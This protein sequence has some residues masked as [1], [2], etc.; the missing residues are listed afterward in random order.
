MSRSHHPSATLVVAALHV[1]GS[2]AAPARADIKDYMISRLIM[3]K[4]ECHLMQLART[5]HTDGTVEFHGTCSNLT[6]YPDGIDI[7]CPELAS[8][9][10]RTCRIK[11]PAKVFKNLDLLRQRE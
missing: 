9:D 2:L 10:E 11:T 8:D 6:F 4:S 1:F 5:E 7:A 3:L